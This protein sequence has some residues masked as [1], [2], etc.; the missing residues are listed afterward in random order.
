MI[1]ISQQ[2]LKDSHNDITIWHIHL[3]SFVCKRY[4]QKHW[5]QVCTSG[6]S[7]GAAMHSAM[8]AA[9]ELEAGQRC[10]VVLPDSVRNYMTKHLSDKW[11]E[12]RDFISEKEDT[13]NKHWFVDSWL[14][15]SVFSLYLSVYLSNSF[16]LFN[17]FSPM[18]IIGWFF[19]YSIQH[20]FL[21]RILMMIMKNMIL[22]IIWI[23]VNENE[24]LPGGRP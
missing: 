8:L 12:E 3:E 22:I 4:K 2:N 10:V 16:S 15:V 9:Q 20:D 24:T 23:W 5:L 11:M 17:Q 13:D 6:G 1:L 14:C 19:Y 18:I 21:N 7:C